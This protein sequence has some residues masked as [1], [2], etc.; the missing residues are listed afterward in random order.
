MVVLL[1]TV[2]A[3]EAGLGGR[4]AEELPPLAGMVVAFVEFAKVVAGGLAVFFAAELFEAV[5]GVEA[6]SRW[7]VPHGMFLPSGCAELAGGVEDPRAE[8]IWNRVVQAVSAPAC[9]N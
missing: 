5:V 3:G 2:D 4:A 7:P 9:E 8:A 1:L 6:S